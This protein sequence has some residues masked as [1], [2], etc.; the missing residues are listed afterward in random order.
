MVTHSRDAPGMKRAALSRSRSA[1]CRRGDRWIASRQTHVG[2][3]QRVDRNERRD[4]G[5]ARTAERDDGDR[6]RRRSAMANELAKRAG[7]RFIDRRAL[8]VRR[9]DTGRGRRLYP[10]AQVV[11]VKS[12]KAEELKL[13]EQYRCPDPLAGRGGPSAPRNP[14]MPAPQVPASGKAVHVRRIT[15]PMHDARIF[16]R[17]RAWLGRLRRTLFAALFAMPTGPQA[18]HAASEAPSE[19]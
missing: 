13:R 12:C 16:L 8:P 4:F 2:S 5:A 19:G 6:R 18:S 3:R 1:T 11:M 17:M 10:Q 7:T 15:S 9:S 14:T